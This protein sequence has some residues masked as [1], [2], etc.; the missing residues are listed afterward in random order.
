[1]I[2]PYAKISDYEIALDQLAWQVVTGFDLWPA[3]DAA[4]L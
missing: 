1:L 4:P 2:S 3:A